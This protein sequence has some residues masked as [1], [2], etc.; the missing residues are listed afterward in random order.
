MTSAAARRI[1]AIAAGALEAS[2]RPGCAVMR[3]PRGTTGNARGNVAAAASGSTLAIGTSS[4]SRS[5][6]FCR[7]SASAIA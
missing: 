6:S 4:P 2:G 1:E 5:A 7:K 3:S